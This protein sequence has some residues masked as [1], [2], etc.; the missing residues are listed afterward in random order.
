[1]G[2]YLSS[3]LILDNSESPS[4][5]FTFPQGTTHGMQII[6][7]SQ[8]GS[9]PPYVSSIQRYNKKYGAEARPPP[10][11]LRSIYPS[12]YPWAI[13]SAAIGFYP[14][15]LGYAIRRWVLPSVV[16]LCPSPLGS[17]LRRWAMPFAIGLYPSVVGLYPP[18]LGCTLRRWVVP[19]IVGLCP[20]PLGFCPPSLGYALRRWA[21]P[22]A[23][24]LL[25]SVVGLC[26][27]LLG[28]CP[29]LLGY[30]LRR[31]ASA[32]RCWAMPFAVGLLP[33]VVGLCPSPLGFCPPSLGSTFCRW[34]LS[35]WH[36]LSRRGGPSLSS[37]FP[38]AEAGLVG[39]RLSVGWNER[40]NEENEPRRSLW[41]V[42]VTHYMG[43]PHPG[44]PLVFF[45][46]L[47]LHRVNL[48]RPHPSGKGRGGCSGVRVL[49][50]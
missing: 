36:L 24:G 47:F 18:S 9:S 25:P 37:L 16:G 19:S 7:N 42:F 38:E 12:S 33:S 26:P 50:F 43:L 41:F 32:L 30:A 8:G 13:S 29:P 48:S 5:K 34:A 28:F 22:F 10:P 6:I 46:P 15:S 1:M 20:S 2:E 39:E 21:M 49:T 23:V 27:S 11:S 40:R 4:F 35:L 31:W 45:P 3:Y 17:I 44:S 14:P